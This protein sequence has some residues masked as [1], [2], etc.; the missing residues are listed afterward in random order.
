MLSW[1][2]MS[3]KW[4]L[5]VDVDERMS[6]SSVGSRFHARGSATENARFAPFVVERGCRCWSRATT[7]VLACRRP[8]WAGRRCSL[9]RDW[10][11]FCEQV[12]TACTQGVTNATREWR[13]L[14]GHVVSGRARVSL[15]RL[16]FSGMMMNLSRI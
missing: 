7:S 16:G 6:F 12:D 1:T 4:C 14:H 9:V 5:N 3:L 10:L 13:K 15:P 8:V 2:R 11:M